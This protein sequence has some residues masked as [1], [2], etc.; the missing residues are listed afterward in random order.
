MDTKLQAIL[1]ALFLALEARAQVS[2]M[3]INEAAADFD[4]FLHQVSSF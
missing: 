1:I 2:L 4:I 3:E